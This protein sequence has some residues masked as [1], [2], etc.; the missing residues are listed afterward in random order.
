[1]ALA[2]TG[3][4]GL[5][6]VDDLTIGACNKGIAKAAQRAVTKWFSSLPAGPIEL[7]PSPILAANSWKLT[8]IGYRLEPG[9]GYG[10][11]PVHVKPWGKRISRF[12]RKLAKRLAGAA[13]N[14]DLF[15]VGEKYRQRWFKGQQAWTKVPFHSDDLS[16][17]ITMVYV[18]DFHHGIPMGTWKVNHPKLTSPPSA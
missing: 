17:C 7:H 13:P 6:F 11:N 16:R 1:M 4:I 3:A 15:A 10:G 8:V 2:D 12:K 5:S 14:S 18:D 9:N